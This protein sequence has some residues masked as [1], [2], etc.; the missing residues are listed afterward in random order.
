MVGNAKCW[1]DLGASQRRQENE[2]LR[3]KRAY[4]EKGCACIHS[5][6][7]LQPCPSNIPDKE[8]VAFYEKHCKCTRSYVQGVK[9]GRR[10]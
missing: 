9:N 1:R 4:F 10:L 5:S 2:R 7:T 6:K 3:E 8:A